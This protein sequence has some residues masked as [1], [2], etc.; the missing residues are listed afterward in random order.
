M[1]SSTGNL[2]V[3]DEDLLDSIFASGDRLIAVHAE[4]ETRIRA[5]T[6]MFIDSERTKDGPPSYDLHSLIRDPQTALIATQRAL[7]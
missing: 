2:L 1:G 7:K 6:A 4:D 5:R 3:D